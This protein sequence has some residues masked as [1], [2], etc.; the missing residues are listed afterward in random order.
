MAVVWAVL[1]AVLLATVS[2]DRAQPQVGIAGGS[3]RWARGV[4]VSVSPE[5]VVLK[6]RNREL[7]LA[8]DLSLE[9][10]PADALA[11]GQIVDAHYVDR[12]GTRRAVIVLGAIADDAAKLSKR[13]GTSVLGTVK[14]A[15]RSSLTLDVAGKSR[16]FGLKKKT[17]L[18]DRD[19]RL[20]AE[21]AAAI[22]ASVSAGDRLL[23]AY[24]RDE[25]A[26]DQAV[27]IR[28]IPAGGSSDR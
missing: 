11:S 13:P 9:V 28:A 17:R 26:G 20:A 10:R 4:V 21:G 16:G 14:K 6:L 24:E 22:V 25:D 23:I 1:C 8:R 15:K 27:E 18:L 2:G 12:R 5:S 7:S 19:G 3:L